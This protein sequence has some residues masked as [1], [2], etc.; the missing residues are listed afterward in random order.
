MSVEYPPL[1]DL[2]GQV[3]SINAMVGNRAAESFAAME[4]SAKILL[5]ETKELLEKGC[6]KRDPLE[7]IDGQSDVAFVLA[8]FQHISGIGIK[9]G[10]V[11]TIRSNLT[12][13]DRTEDDAKITAERYAAK[14]IKTRYSERSVPPDLQHI[15]GEVCFVTYADGDQQIGDSFTPDGKWLKSYK[16]E[17]PQH[18]L[19]QLTI[20]E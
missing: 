11:E 4:R 7:I 9:P 5:S 16:F 1:E 19:T 12:K 20:T 2:F 17:E 15:L 13:F 14:G 8:G 10:L 6:Q 18:D 3:A